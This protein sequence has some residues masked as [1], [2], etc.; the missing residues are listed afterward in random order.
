MLKTK[1]RIVTIVIA[2]FLMISISASV[3][4]MPTAKAQ[5]TIPINITTYA[6]VWAAP[7]TIGV[8]Q[9]AVIYI[10][11]TATLPGAAL[12]NDIRFH[13]YEC[14]ITAPN[15]ATETKTFAVISDPTS[16]QQFSYTP[17][18]VGTYTFNFTFPGQVYNYNETVSMMG[19]QSST[20]MYVG[21]YYEPSNASATLTAQQTAL[22]AIPYNPLP[23]QYWTRPI[24]G[25]NSN[26]YTI[27]SNW[28]GTGSPP[29]QSLNFGYAFYVSDAI[30]S[31]TSHIM[32]TTPL[33]SGGVVGGNDTAIPG[34]TYF[35]GS[36]YINRYG[37]PIIL[38]GMLYY[39][40]PL[41]FASASGGATYCVNLQTGQ[42]IWSSTTIIPPSFGLLYDQ[43]DPNQHGVWPPIIVAS[44]GGF[45]SIV[46][47]G[48]WIAYDGDTGDWLFNMTNVP[49]GTSV[50]GPSGEILTYVLAND[51]TPTKPQYYLSE[52]NSSSLF[53]AEGS[54]SPTIQGTVVNANVPSAYDWNV[55]VSALNT[56]ATS[57]IAFPTIVAAYYD[58]MMLCYN[59]TLPSAGTTFYAQ[60]WTPYTYFA[61]NLNPSEGTV[62]S[63]L[64]MQTEQPPAGN[65]TVLEGGHDQNVFIELYKETM[66]YVGYSMATG[67]KLW[68]PTASHPALD[69]YGNDFGGNLNA[70]VAYGD[71]Y[72]V[73][74]AGILYCYNEKTGDV[75]WTYGNGGEGNSTYAGLNNYYGVYPTFITA[76]G[77]GIIYT[78]TTAHTIETPI[79]KGALTRA[80][81]A[82]TGAELWTLS[83]YTGGG[84]STTSY[85]IADGYTTFFNGYD[86]QIYVVGQGPSATTVTASPSV[87]TFG[88]NVLIQ[89]SV[90]DISAGTK[91]NEQAADFPNGVPCASD[92]S[93]A[94]WMGYVYQQQPM[95]T[96]FTGVQVQISVLDSNGNYR[97]I[98][99]ATTDTSGT[100]RLTWTPNIAG[101]YTVFASFAGNNGYYP[102]SAETGFNVMNAPS[103]TV[104]PTASPTSV[105][106]LYFVPAIT[107]LFVLII[108]VAIVL[109][110]LML[111]KKP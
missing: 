102:S 42:L 2:I 27:S 51:G 65:I 47:P 64:W 44:G 32:W 109:A 107:G 59:G 1:N 26:W 68:G 24:Y 66:Q 69:Y 87:Q 34:D 74:F 15:G 18:Q 19:M 93:M 94:Q 4:L 61:V 31:Q 54:L 12:G 75:L 72:S 76:I 53:F 80:I 77:N 97:N 82:T 78:E 16:S 10:W 13:N 17:S 110:L 91:Q 38:D 90:M 55:S 100:Y 48:T 60:S 45:G 22:S 81:N 106:D 63:V 9:T 7:S 57:A 89:G 20:S 43:Q 11:L 70:Q 101:N 62:G 84:G 6:Y 25:T 85:A 5:S 36:A 41:S 105:A 79:Y 103:A 96:N 14:T 99:T 58:D 95:P 67:A 46:P 8:G 88:D 28:L 98:D 50:L 35:E 92:A 73:G 108:V 86:N 52:W 104:A 29:I 23:T 40:A 37:N 33:Q 3:M 21:D 49:T 30:G 83:D 39:T 71:V 111:R 56:L